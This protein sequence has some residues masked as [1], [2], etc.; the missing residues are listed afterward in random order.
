MV[1]N[2]LTLAALSPLGITPGMIAERGLEPHVEAVETEVVEIDAGGRAFRL[3]PAA[4]AA[5]RD[6]KH[7]AAE[8][9]VELVLVS[10]FRSVRS[11]TGIIERK[12]AAGM[13]IEE[14]LRVNAPPGYSEHHTGRAVDI[15]S[16]GVTELSEDFE[17]TG[18]FLWL[19]RYA[20]HFGFFMPYGRDNSR[21]YNYEPWH[22]TYAHD[23][24]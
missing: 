13:S 9:G 3:T 20:H 7:H 12:L 5:W 4:A 21:G 18:A 6:M 22:W 19:T 1:A 8:D 10:A 11:Q 23:D 2:L 17:N 16:P 15:G 24:D 14:I